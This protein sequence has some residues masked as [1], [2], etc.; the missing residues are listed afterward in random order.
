MLSVSQRRELP[1]VLWERSGCEMGAT[2]SRCLVSGMVEGSEF[3]L[4]EH[5]NSVIQVSEEKNSAVSVQ[6][7]HPGK[8][9]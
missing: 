6:N 3:V 1:V 5:Y 2:A 4:V 9:G 7:F 8:A